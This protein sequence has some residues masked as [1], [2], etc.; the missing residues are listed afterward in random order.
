MIGKTIQTISFLAGL[1]HILKLSGPHLI[2]TPLAV[3]QNWANEINRFCPTISF[4]KLYGS[5]NERK[6][7]FTDEL[8]NTCQ[9]DI[10]LTT[11]ETLITEEAFFTD[12]WSWVTITIDEGHR[13]KNEN[14]KLRLALSRLRCP[15]RLLLTGKMSFLR[16]YST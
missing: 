5:A 8:V 4:K 9:Y 14:A 1:K 11:Y 2:V 3:L 16:E 10:Y 12:S 15:F 7:L 13:I 6:Q